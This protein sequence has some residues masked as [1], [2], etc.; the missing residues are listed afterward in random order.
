MREGISTNRLCTASSACLAAAGIEFVFRY[1]SRTTRQPEKQLRREEA[2]ALSQAGLAI[3]VVYQDRG[4]KIDDFNFERGMLDGNSAV[5]SA[6]RIGQPGNSA[7]YF[8]VD[9]DFDSD[10]IRN[11]VFKYFEGVRR[12]FEDAGNGQALFRVGVY[13]SGLT[14][15]LLLGKGL[16]SYAWLAEA[17]GWRESRTFNDWHVRQVVNQTHLCELGKNW[18]R[19]EAIADFGQFK[20]IGSEVV[21]GTGETRRVIAS[22]LNL[23]SMPSDSGNVPIARLPHG[24]FVKLLGPA[25]PGW[26]RV[27]A[28]LDGAMFEGYVSERYLEPEQRA[29]AAPQHRLPNIPAVHWTENNPNSKRSGTSGLASP[30]GENPRPNRE[31]RATVEVKNEQLRVLADWLDVERSARYQPRDGRTYCNV[32]VADYC[33]LAQ[34]YLPRVWW[35]SAAVA[36]LANGQ[37]VTAAY[38]DTIR[39]MRADDIYRWLLDF[40]ALFGW[41][42]AASVSELQHAANGGGVGII[43]ADRE[44]EGRSGHITIVVPENHE[45]LAKRNASGVL[46]Q[47]LQTQAGERNK[48]YGSSGSNWWLGKQFI[49]YV[50]Y[51]HD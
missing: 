31:S 32:Y 48:R 14:C 5:A 42:R 46:E 21:R 23:R 35:T 15:R 51:V 10:V 11:A 47:P 13:G 2:E 28:Q 40:G 24:S 7:I 27:V 33:Y 19:C 6:G 38:G 12:G 26:V 22:I 49:D 16:A 4:R 45:Q 9:T 44:A 50:F 39:E 25:S 17:T 20:P 34:V 1:Y 43:C 3:A 18:E 37:K 30:I 36:R 41:R 8:A 29:Q